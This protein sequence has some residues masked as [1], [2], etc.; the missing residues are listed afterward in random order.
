M[1][2]RVEKIRIESSDK[3]NGFYCN[4]LLFELPKRIEFPFDV[5]YFIFAYSL[6]V[7]ILYQRQSKH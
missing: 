4:E 7:T 1:F 5:I 6:H 3:V 2:V